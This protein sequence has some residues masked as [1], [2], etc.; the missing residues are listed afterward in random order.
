MEPVFQ[1]TKRPVQGAVLLCSDGLCHYTTR[2]EL[3][4]LLMETDSREQLQQRLQ[5]AVGFCRSCGETDNI[6]ALALKWNDLSSL[7]SGTDDWIEVW[8]RLSGEA[9]P[10]EYNQKLGRIL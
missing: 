5:A 10:I 1:C 4:R 8:A 7:T 6:T 9:A 3:H 2:K